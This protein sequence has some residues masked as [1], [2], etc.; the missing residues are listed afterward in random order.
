ML[1]EKISGK[2]DR[3]KKKAEGLLNNPSAKVKDSVRKSLQ[4]SLKAEVKGIEEITHLDIEASK[5]NLSHFLNMV[6]KV[7]LN[8]LPG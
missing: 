5:E 2:V 7:W 8:T 4:S 3:R 6:H 1:G